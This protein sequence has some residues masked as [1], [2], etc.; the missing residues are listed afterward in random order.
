MDKTQFRRQ[1]LRWFDSH[2]RKHLP[3]QQNPSPYRVWVSEIMLQQTQVSTVIP[4][5]KKFMA[6]F[7]SLRSL[8]T[9]E[10]DQVLQHWSG[11]GYYARARNLHRSATIIATEHKGRFPDNVDA[12]LAL[13]G[14]GRSTAGAILSLAKNQHHA[15]LDGNVKRVLARFAAI[16][17]W[18]GNREV[19]DQL[20]LLSEQLTPKKRVAEFNQAMMDL[21][22]TLCTRSKPQCDACPLQKQCRAQQLDQVSNYPGKKPR[23]TLPVRKT[24][25][26]ILIAENNHI[27][28]ERRPASGLWG[29]LLCFPQTDCDLEIEPWCTQHI[30][31]D[32][33]RKQKQATLRHTFSH[34]HLDITPVHVWIK[35]N[36]NRVMEQG[37]WVW[38][39]DSSTVGG[40]PA[41]VS[42]L[43]K[44]IA[45]N[46]N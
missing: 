7:P 31:S 3:W 23:K 32:V 10:L 33:Y 28:M 12:V 39:K 19:L 9:A 16:A 15:I 35:Q 4:Y 17:G 37:R 41:P 45:L 24:Q 2:G 44:K 25:M 21:G 5:Y 40:L 43:L 30:N 38:Y 8:A 14:I 27:L 18:P 26:L 6:T 42:Q 29:G 1:V 13:P 46:Y 36:S 22:A 34:F 20:W 11:L